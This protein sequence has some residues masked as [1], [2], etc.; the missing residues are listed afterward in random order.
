MDTVAERLRKKYEDACAAVHA[1]TEPIIQRGEGGGA[2]A[3]ADELAETKRLKAAADAAKADYEKQR[4]LEAMVSETPDQA[5]IE[6]DLARVN[7]AGGAEAESIRKAVRDNLGSEGLS[8]YDD[9]TGAQL[10][11]FAKLSESGDRSISISVNPTLA[12]NLAELTA[13]GVSAGDYVTALRS[14]RMLIAERRNKTS[15]V[16]AYNI[17]TSGEGKELV[18][19]F[20]DNALYLFASYIG[21]VQAAG[22]TTIPVMGNNTLKMPKVTGYAPGLNVSG[23]GVALTSESKDA[24]NT[25]DLT[26]RPYRGY[27]AETDEI[28]RAAVIDVRML[29]V[30]RGL[31]RALQLGKENDFHNGNGTGKPKGILHNVPAARIQKTGGNAVNIRYGDIPAALGLLDA[32]YHSDTRA[33]SI[34]SLMH[35]ATWFNAFVG[36]VASDGHPIYPHLAQGGGNIFGTNRVFSHAMQAAPAADALLAV[37]GNF[38][39]FYVIATMGGSE[40][41]VSDDLR[42]LSFERVYRIQEYCDGTPRDDK[43]AAFIQSAD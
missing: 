42:F 13:L 29:L 10:A 16:R 22:A 3:T 1:Y 15:D 17:A 27:T 14:G 41:T 7:E 38:S 19:T 37:V 35:S 39:D 12:R 43:A 28:M 21:G 8:S 33:G 36:A 18:P 32:E 24:T 11:D 34:S 4:D 5:A 30:L 40:I 26:P 6:R 31:A 20:W 23:E 9:R 2:V 25:V